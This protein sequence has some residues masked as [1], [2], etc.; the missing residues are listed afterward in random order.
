MLSENETAISK[1]GK[2]RISTKLRKVNVEGSGYLST[3]I[4]RGS[5][6]FLNTVQSSCVN[7]GFHFGLRCYRLARPMVY[8]IFLSLHI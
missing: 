1:G 8:T 6:S 5:S 2:E 3:S 4:H 7:L